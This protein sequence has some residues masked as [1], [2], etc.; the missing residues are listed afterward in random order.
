MKKKLF[1]HYLISGRVQGVGYRAFVKRAAD[2]LHLKGKVRNLKDG[3][4][5]AIVEASEEEHAMLELELKQGPSH[6][7]VEGLQSRIV[8]GSFVW[9]NFSIDADCDLLGGETEWA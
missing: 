4:V 7:L 2:H 6:A 9:E 8:D 5:E 3:R 1:R